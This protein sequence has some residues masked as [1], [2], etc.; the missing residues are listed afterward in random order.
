MRVI[1]LLKRMGQERFRFATL[2]YYEEYH[3]N[4]YLVEKIKEVEKD[5][6][7]RTHEMY[8]KL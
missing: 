3:H 5:I 8:G 1:I 6:T 2:L 7:V 4:R